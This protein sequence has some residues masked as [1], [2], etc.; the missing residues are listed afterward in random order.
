[1]KEF[2]VQKLQIKKELIAAK[3]RIHISFDLWILSNSLLIV[4]I[5][6]YYL[7]KDLVVQSTL[8]GIRRVK[9]VYSG[10]N[11]AKAI[12]PV[13]VKMGVVLKLRFFIRDN[14]RNNDICQRV[15]CRKL[16]P[17][18]KAPDSRRVRCLSYILNLAVKAFL[19]GK[20]A[21]AF[22]EDVNQKYNN[23]YIEKLQKLWHKKGLIRKF[24]NIVL[25]CDGPGW[26]CRPVDVEQQQQWC[27]ARSRWRR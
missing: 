9:G 2:E 27:R 7:N 18:I 19:F 13:L 26:S 22:E 5:V 1:M 24:Y 8:I 25:Y 23:I 11:I 16:R 15:I 12:I 3:T 20:E 6:T 4:G 10:E 14:I 21:D 17:D